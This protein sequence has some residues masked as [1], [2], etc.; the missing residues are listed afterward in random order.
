LI[1]S[2]HTWKKGGVVADA[3]LVEG[4][5][6]TVRLERELPDPPE[7]VW[8]ALTDPSELARWFPC[9]VEVDGAQ[10]VAGATISF[11]FPPDVIDLTLTGTV[12]EVDEPRVLAYTWGDE[13]LRFELSP[14]GAGTTLVLYDT[15][16]PEAGARNAAGWDDCL[17]HLMGIPT[18]PSNW[19]PRFE[20]YSA[21]FSPVLGPQ[22]GPPAGYKG[23]R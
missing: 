1:A 11:P 19:R 16:S 4:G 18:T 8:Q 6:P 9:G 22:E 7:V 5:D 21:R 15:L 3:R 13:Q 17:D 2:K 10:W 20:V 12:L 23:D 14:N